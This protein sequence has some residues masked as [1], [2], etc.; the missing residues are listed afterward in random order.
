MGNLIPNYVSDFLSF[1]SVEKGLSDSHIE[2]QGRHLGDFFLFLEGKAASL[3]TE[4]DIRQYLSREH[5]R[6]LAGASLGHRIS[7][8]RGFFAFLLDEGIIQD[9][10]AKS[11]ES[12]EREKPLPRFLS[13]KQIEDLFAIVEDPRDKAIFEI[14]YASGI[15]GGELMGLQNGDIDLENTTL[16][17][18]KAKNG[19]ERVAYL[20]KHA[21]EAIRAYKK[22]EPWDEPFL[23]FETRANL[24]RIFAGYGE[25]LGIELSPH[26][27]RHSCATHLLNNGAHVMAVKEILGHESI[28]AT[29][30]YTHVSPEKLKK[31]H[32]A[33]FENE[34]RVKRVQEIERKRREKKHPRPDLLKKLYFVVECMSKEGREAP[35]MLSANQTCW[36]M[37][38][39][40]GAIT[41]HIKAGRI[42]APVISDGIFPYGIDSK[43]V[44][45]LL[46]DAPY[47]LQQA[48]GHSQKVKKTQKLSWEEWAKK[49]YK[50]FKRHER[51]PYPNANLRAQDR[52]KYYSYDEMADL[53][54]VSYTTYGQKIKPLV[55]LLF[56]AEKRLKA[57]LLMDAV[58]RDFDG[59]AGRKA[60]PRRTEEEILEA[61]YEIAMGKI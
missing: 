21:V 17:I 18:Q 20:N 45:E 59:R 56:K 37:E 32:T 8:L 24:S 42:K 16:R 46:T 35:Y 47:W 51:L 25:K 49:A 57:D 4:A 61:E 14:L 31:D 44:E 22:L 54:G 27:L 50:I 39:E 9:S 40:H 23:D 1:L 5:E 36:I 33:F 55:D 26:M 13:E 3:V 6:G 15:R 52:T 38:L 53:L 12:P 41:R 19:R 60:L 29:M 43:H 34:A 2:A 7:A 11:I 48:W 10:P 58:T 28:N 30:V